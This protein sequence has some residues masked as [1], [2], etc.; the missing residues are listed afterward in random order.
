M[1]YDYKSSL[2]NDMLSKVTLILGGNKGDR[3]RLLKSAVDKVL[4]QGNLIKASLVYET[5]AWGGI[6]KGPFLNQ[7]MQVETEKNPL[8]FLVFIQSIETELGRKRDEHWG[9]RTMDIDILF[10]GEMVIDAPQLKIPHPFIQD[11]KFVL[12]PLNEICSEFYHPVIRKSIHEL[13]MECQDPS[14]V[15]PYKK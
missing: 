13:L 5:E 3:E 12:I 10:W 6:A 8:E 15:I 11:R 2:T 7:V 14:E 4:Q 9:D 1:A